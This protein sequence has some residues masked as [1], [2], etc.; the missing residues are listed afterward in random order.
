MPKGGF[1]HTSCLLFV[2]VLCPLCLPISGQGPSL[3]TMQ[4]AIATFVGSVHRVTPCWELEAYARRKRCKILQLVVGTLLGN[5]GI[6]VH[7]DNNSPTI[8]SGEMHESDDDHMSQDVVQILR[9]A[10]DMS[11]S[12]RKRL[13][14]ERQCTKKELL[15]GRD[16]CLPYISTPLEVS[17]RVV[18]QLSAGV[19]PR[20]EVVQRQ[21]MFS[22]SCDTFDVTPQDRVL[23]M[24]CADAA[25][26][27]QSSATKCDVHVTIWSTGVAAAGDVRRWATW[28]MA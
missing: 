7:R 20:V 21:F 18:L 17:S 14:L 15:A 28:W 16:K 5:A 6:V 9:T 26:L 1:L 8:E 25:P 10:C 19:C 12:A 11:P 23:I 2:Y 24:I 13:Y 22:S 27:W 4:K 3:Q